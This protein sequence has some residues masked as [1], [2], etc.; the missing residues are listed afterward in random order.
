VRALSAAPDRLAVRIDGIEHTATWAIATLRRHYAGSFVISPDARLDD[1]GIHIVLFSAPSRRALAAQI[2]AVATG[3]VGHHPG[4][5]D[6][7]G[8]TIEIATQAPVPI[9]IDG[10]P[11][12]TTPC[13]ITARGPALR[14][15]VPQETARRQGR[16]NPQPPA[17]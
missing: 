14:L 12:G 15:L 9:Q 3:R 4:V 11:F 17:R 6:V 2:L 8:T 7:V 5:T 10:E 13:R 16:V 1:T